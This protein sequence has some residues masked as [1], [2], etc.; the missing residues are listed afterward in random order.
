MIM[1]PHRAWGAEMST[2]YH[3]RSRIT[4]ARELLSDRPFFAAMVPMV[5]EIRILKV[6]VGEVFGKM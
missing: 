2:D 6:G 5:I 3:Q 1:L 4:A